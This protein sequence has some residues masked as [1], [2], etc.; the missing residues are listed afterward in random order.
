MYE[1]SFVCSFV[2]ACV[3][4]FVRADGSNRIKGEISTGEISTGEVRF[5]HESAAKETRNHGFNCTHT[6]RNRRRPFSAPVTATTATAELR[7]PRQPLRQSFS[8]SQGQ[9]RHQF[10]VSAGEG[11]G[12]DVGVDFG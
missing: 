8:Q 6:A 12:E 5:S 10:W 3:R 11:E 2:R 9:S 4:V 1:K 7:R